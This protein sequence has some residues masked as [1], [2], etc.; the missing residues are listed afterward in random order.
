MSRRTPIVVAAI[1]ALLVSGLSTAPVSADT[2]R[3]QKLEWLALRLVN[4]TRTGGKVKENGSCKGFG[5]GR[6]ST[7]QKPLRMHRPISDAI[8]VAISAGVR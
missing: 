5:S 1:L 7:F 3:Y 4:C 8:W 2:K 6:F